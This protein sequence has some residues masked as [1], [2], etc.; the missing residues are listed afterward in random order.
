MISFWRLL[1]LLGLLWSLVAPSPAAAAQPG[2]TAAPPDAG[3]ARLVAGLSPQQKVGQLFLVTFKGTAI[4]ESSPIF[5]LI[6]R[7]H[8]GGVVL[9]SGNDNFADQDFATSTQHLAT[10]LQAVAAGVAPTNTGTP[11]QPA[12]GFQYVP[13][14]IGT[15][16]S[17]PAV[18][19]RLQLPTA[20]TLGATWS[21]ER[22]AAIGRLEGRDL[23][24][25][26]VNLLFGPTLDA[27]IDNMR[28]FR[29]DVVAKVR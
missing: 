9:L 27:T 7:N 24:A 2:Q 17:Q 11:S 16:A 13:L 22:A 12:S 14:F 20:M 23:A 5:E 15:S 21:L 8:V 25:L 1:F 29:D 3:I 26:G 18:A 6:T 4:D 28:K 19:S 10:N